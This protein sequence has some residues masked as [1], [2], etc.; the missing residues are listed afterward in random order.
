M[1]SA[2][3]VMVAV[4]GLAGLLLVISLFSGW[5]GASRLRGQGDDMSEVENAARSFVEAY[6]S[7]DFREPDAYRDRLL[8]LSTGVVHEAI[9]TSQVDPT[10]LGQQH[11]ISTE[12]VSVDVTAFSGD[13]ATASATS[14]QTRRAIDPATGQ[15]REQRLR[16]HIA[17]RL[18]R[19]DGRWLV[20]EFRL[21][22]QEPIESNGR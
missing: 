13:A 5:Q 6:G 1:T 12:S 8:G 10:A 2:R 16:Q 21:T 19:V 20:A 14:E 15:L 9:A 11:T 18:I 4:G 7:F 17:C 3:G 22:S